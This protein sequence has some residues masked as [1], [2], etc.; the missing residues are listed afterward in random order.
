MIQ[1]SFSNNL[2]KKNIQI[3]IAAMEITDFNILSDIY[4]FDQKIREIKS[5]LKSKYTINNI[6]EDPII[7]K[8]RK[9]Y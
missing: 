1:I 6:K 5:D 3:S 8:Y 9:F 7:A 2:L 4:D